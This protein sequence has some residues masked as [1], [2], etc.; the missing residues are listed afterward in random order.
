MLDKWHCILYHTHQ[1]AGRIEPFYLH[2]YMDA[3]WHTCLLEFL[4]TCI[5]EYLHT[6]ILVYWCNY[7][8]VCYLNSFILAYLY[9]CILTH[10][11]T[12]ILVCWNNRYSNLDQSH[13][14]NQQLFVHLLTYLDKQSLKEISSLKRAYSENTTPKR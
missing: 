8:L 13:L 6:Y 5:I 11:Y 7:L 3:Y 14:S 12:C 1:D 4:H 9:T 2:T 10:L